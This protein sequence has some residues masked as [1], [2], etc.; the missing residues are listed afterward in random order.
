MSF[1]ARKISWS[2]SQDHRC[3]GCSPHKAR[4]EANGDS[5]ASPRHHLDESAG[6]IQGAD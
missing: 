3:N 2:T 4:G 6:S 5:C 1:P